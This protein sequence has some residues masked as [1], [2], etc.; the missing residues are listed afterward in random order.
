MKRL[1]RSKENSVIA[2][3]CAGVGE[4][5]DVDPVLI[6]LGAVILFFSG[7]G[8]PAILFAYLIGYFIIP[9]KT[10]S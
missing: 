7:L 1:Y 8:T 3:I 6:R 4:Y 10:S 2:G 5:C 9:E